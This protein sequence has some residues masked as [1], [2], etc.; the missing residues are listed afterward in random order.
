MR[1][2]VNVQKHRSVRNGNQRLRSDLS[3]ARRHEFV[4]TCDLM[5]S[6]ATESAGESCLRLGAV[7]LGFF[8]Q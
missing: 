1:I 6:D 5:I 3:V 8:D 2:M 4:E 7:E